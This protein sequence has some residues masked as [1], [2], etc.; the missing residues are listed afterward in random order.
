MRQP[1]RTPVR[2]GEVDVNVPQ[3]VEQLLRSPTHAPCVTA[4][5]H[6]PAREAEF[7][8][9]PDGLDGRLRGVLERRGIRRLYSHQAEALGRVM[10]GENACV[11]T[12]TSS[13]KTLCYNLPVLNTSLVD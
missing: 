6:L 10:A 12:P 3:V 8:E 11:V 2:A 4:F 9:W 7:G 1:I 13:G 5:R